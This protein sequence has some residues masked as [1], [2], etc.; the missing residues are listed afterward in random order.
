[1]KPEISI[2]Y[3]LA[4]S[5]G[6]IISRCLG[7]IPGNILLSEVHP[8]YSFYHPLIQARDW[9]D[10]IT[11]D[12]L[13]ELKS[14]QGISYLDSIKLIS[15]RCREKGLNLIIRDWTHIDF[16]T[17]PYPARPTYRMSQYDLLKE[18]FEI[19]HIAIARDPVDSYL[20]LSRLEEF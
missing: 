5:G 4:R 12:E 7:C 11:E 1:M 6:T 15:D 9:F 20:S 14:I 8:G 10:L 13:I 16:I 3:S 17:S 19:R 2:I 18:H